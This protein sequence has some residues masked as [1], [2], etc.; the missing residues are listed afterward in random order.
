MHKTDGRYGGNTL[1]MKKHNFSGLWITTE[2]FA[3][4]KPR[5]VFHRQLDTSVNLPEEHTNKHILFR[6]KLHIDEQF[7]QA[8]LYI[9]ADDYYKLYI[10]G[11]FVMQ[12]PA[13]CYPFSY[14]YQTL[15]VSKFLR[16]GDNVIA[17]HT[18][19][20]GLIN[21]VWVSG[22]NRHGLLCDLELDGKTCLSSDDSFLTHMHSGYESMGTVGYKTQ[23]LEKYNSNAKEVGFTEYAFDDSDWEPAKVRNFTDYKLVPQPT[24]NLVFEQ[25]EPQV[26]TRE[27]NRMIIDFGKC[28]VGYLEVTVFGKNGEVV[29]VRCG[30]ELN[31]DGTVRY[32][33]RAAC[34][35]EEQWVLSDGESQLKWFDYKAFRYVELSLPEGCKVEQIS[36]TARHYPF[37]LKAQPKKEYAS[38]PQLMDIW[39]LCV[40]SL[41]YG[42]QEVIQDCM[43]REKGFYV[44]DGCYTALAHMLL[45]HDDSM[46]RYLIDSARLSSTFVESTVTC[47]NCSFMQEIAEYPLILVSLVLW[48]YRVTGDK[49]YLRKNYEFVR[50]LVDIYRRDYEKDGLLQNLDKWCVVEWPA[51]YRDGYDVDIQEGKVC[52]PAHMVINAYYIEA[53]TTLNKMAEILEEEPYRELAVIKEQF[54]A[55]FYDEERHVFTD[56]AST[57]HSSYISN[58]FAYGFGLV[59]DEECEKQILAQVK[60]KGSSNTF[61]FS[62]FPLLCGLIRNGKQQVVKELLLDDG[63]WLRMLREGATTTFEGWGKECKWNTSLFH[64]T[65]AYASV[66]IADVEHE[67]LF[68]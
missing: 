50:N 46:V 52:E 51:N 68:Q 61:L 20:Q 4:L 55:A 60:E 23:F 1:K 67:R 41:Q 14:G 33:L 65:M 9:T 47:L 15:D 45:T 16:K 10:N 8:T 62:T 19:Y 53:I 22:D 17:V 38:N 40:H 32:Q 64:L 7:E 43:E 28:Y 42:V 63:A 26:I 5:N 57:T 25:I 13:P 48:H 29:T 54:C 39:N 56:S 21:R 31:S 49:A 58:V 18:Y 37:E 35:Y 3:N 30:Q 27:D 24:N 66:F 59:P 2:E 11:T 6:R 36:L 34:K 44:G 12:G